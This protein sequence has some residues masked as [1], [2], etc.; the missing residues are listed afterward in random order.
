MKRTQVYL[1]EDIWKLLQILARQSKTS[2]SDL[3]RTA[4]REKYFGGPKRRTTAFQ[5]IVGL[6]A[7]R[8]DLKDTEL[9]IRDLRKDDRLT[10][11]SH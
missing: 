6:W 10:R 5:S 8:T 9:F 4:I 1:E 11:L 7:G 3:V 2:I